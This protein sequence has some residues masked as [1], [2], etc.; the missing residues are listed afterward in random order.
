MGLF[1]SVNVEYRTDQPVYKSVYGERRLLLDPEKKYRQCP[2]LY[3]TDFYCV[4]K[5]HY[6][7]LVMTRP[8]S[9]ADNFCQLYLI[10]LDW[11]DNDFLIRRH[12]P[13]FDS[14]TYYVITCGL[15]I[16]V[17]FTEDM[18]ISEETKPTGP[19]FD[20]EMIGFRSGGSVGLRKNLNCDVCNLE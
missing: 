14:T 8:G 19:I 20:V 15:W 4:H 5:P 17:F 7:T 12:L 1:M 13:Y 18:N 11:K 16:E 9:D 6:V 10:K 3:F 2:N